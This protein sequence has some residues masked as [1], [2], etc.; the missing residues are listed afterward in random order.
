MNF[1]A[2]PYEL[3]QEG[4]A[5]ACPLKVTL[6][7]FYG[8]YSTYTP[9]APGAIEWFQTKMTSFTFLAP[10]FQPFCGKEVPGLCLF[11]LFTIQSAYTL[12]EVFDLV[13][14]LCCRYIT[15]QYVQ[16]EAMLITHVLVMH[17]CIHKYA[18][19]RT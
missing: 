19:T 8:V 10:C 17:K 4:E 12:L 16:K 7:L 5:D 1:K 14:L 9:G 11:Q 6:N 13:T 2:N 3:N 15:V 18:M